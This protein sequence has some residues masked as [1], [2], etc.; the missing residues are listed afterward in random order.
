MFKKI[1]MFLGVLFAVELVLVAGASAY[2]FYKMDAPGVTSDKMSGF[3]FIFNWSGLDPE[4]VFMVVDSS[5]N[6]ILWNGDYARS[7]CLVLSD[8]IP[9]EKESDWRPGNEESETFKEVRRFAYEAVYD[10]N[11]FDGADI[12]SADVNAYFWSVDF[13]GRDNIEGATVIFVQ[14]STNKLLFIDWMS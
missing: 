5:Q 12:N 7:A 2:L 3:E 14:K 11:C 9:K 10:G 8:S 6:S 1:L 13:H 4:Q